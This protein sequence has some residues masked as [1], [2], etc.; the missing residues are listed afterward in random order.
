MDLFRQKE[1]SSV[2][3]LLL[4]LNLSQNQ[5]QK[6]L[7]SCDFVTNPHV[8]WLDYE[9]RIWEQTMWNFSSDAWRFKRREDIDDDYND[10]DHEDDDENKNRLMWNI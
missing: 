8:I 5:K 9:S 1:T 4:S 10:N 6:V 2:L 3:F 7:I